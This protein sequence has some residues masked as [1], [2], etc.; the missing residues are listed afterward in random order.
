MVMCPFLDWF[1]ISM[2]KRH[3]VSRMCIFVY[4][5]VPLF[6]KLKVVARQRLSSFVVSQIMV[7]HQD[8]L[9][10]LTCIRL[11]IYGE[12]PLFGEAISLCFSSRR[13]L[14]MVWQIR[15]YYKRLSRCSRQHLPVLVCS[16][17]SRSAFL[18]CDKPAPHPVW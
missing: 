3:N 11:A 14:I 8:Q 4:T 17:L 10:T 6:P 9:H 18:A 15:Q 7:P 12:I 16:E 13:P 2:S 1:V 5:Y